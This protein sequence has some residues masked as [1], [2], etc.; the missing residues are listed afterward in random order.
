MSK[1][2]V[3][4]ATVTV[5]PGIEK[6]DV[7][8]ALRTLGTVSLDYCDSV[9]YKP[10]DKLTKEVWV[11][12]SSD[13][14]QPY[15][16]V[17]SEFETEGSELSDYEVQNLRNFGVCTRLSAQY[18]RASR[19]GAP[20]YASSDDTAAIVVADNLFAVAERD[21]EVN[22]RDRGDDGGDELWFCIAMPE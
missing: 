20:G 17:A 13:E 10:A 19:Y 22:A 7:L 9:E 14:E 21:F 5:H 2:I 18:P 6:D 16:Q 15:I 8:S 3:V 12:S 11:Y 4:K 1:K